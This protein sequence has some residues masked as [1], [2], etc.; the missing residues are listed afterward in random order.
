MRD[1]DGAIGYQQATVKRCNVYFPA[2]ATGAG[3]DDE[4]FGPTTEVTVVEGSIPAIPPFAFCIDDGKTLLGFATLLSQP[5][6]LL[7]GI[8]SFLRAHFM[9][10][11][12]HLN[13]YRSLV[14]LCWSAAL[15]TATLGIIGARF[16]LQ[17]FGDVLSAVLVFVAAAAL[18]VLGVLLLQRHTATA[19]HY[20]PRLLILTP[21]SF[22][23]TTINASFKGAAKVDPVSGVSSRFPDISV[24]I[25][26][27][28]PDI[29]V[30]TPSCAFTFF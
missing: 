4:P 13:A 21:V 1:L 10:R 26:R 24:S 9:H 25:F 18:G 8:T 11:H 23:A 19:Q 12:S 17:G 2:N 22:V 14:V 5:M 30:W 27:F 6:L 20:G 3:D 15:W 7:V 16:W 28:P 29:S